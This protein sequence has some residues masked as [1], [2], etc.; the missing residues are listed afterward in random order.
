MDNEVRTQS[1]ETIRLT[2]TSQT[3]ISSA[4]KSLQSSVKTKANKADVYTQSETEDL[5]NSELELIKSTIKEEIGS[6]S[7]SLQSKVDTVDGKQ[8]SSNDFTN[9]HK[10]K[11]ESLKQGL[12]GKDGQDGKQGEKG[13][14]GLSA[15]DLAKQQG[16]DGSL[17][18][19]LKSLKGDRGQSGVNGLDGRDGK[20]GKDG[21]SAYEIAVKKGFKGT[22]AQWLKSLR[23]KDG[24]SLQGPSGAS[25]L[26]AYQIAVRNGFVGSEKD[27]LKSLRGSG[28]S[29]SNDYNDL[30]NTPNLELY[31]LKDETFDKEEI[32][33]L[34]RTHNGYDDT[35]IRDKINSLQS[36][37]GGLTSGSD[38]NYIHNQSQSL[39]VWNINHNLNK[40]PSVTIVDTAGSVVEGEITFISLNEIRVAFSSPFSGKAILN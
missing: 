23:G 16:Y 38:S 2:P 22:E 20:D 32:H 11:L 9:E 39:E 5:L 7:T 6:I 1:G 12:D 15:Y 26:S 35:E 18:D 24:K 34:L 25:G 30:I 14:D 8:L 40:Y 28:S 33:E 13:E 31:A 29:I 10:A 36:Q 3:S 27:W 21:L 37:I 19:W 17:T 4:I